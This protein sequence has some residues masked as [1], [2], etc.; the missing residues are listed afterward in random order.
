MLRRIKIVAGYDWTSRQANIDWARYSLVLDADDPEYI[1]MLTSGETHLTEADRLLPILGVV[2]EPLVADSWDDLC[3]AVF[4]H[5]VVSNNSILS[6]S[7]TWPW[8]PEA[9][10]SAHRPH[11][12]AYLTGGFRGR[13]NAPLRRRLRDALIASDVDCHLWGR[14][15]SG[16]KSHKVMGSYHRRD[17]SRI[18]TQYKYALAIE[19]QNIDN[20]ITEK[21]VNPINCGMQVICVGASNIRD[22]Y[23]SPIHLDTTR[24]IDHLKEL[25]SRPPDVEA[26]ARDREKFWDEYCFPARIGRYIASQSLTPH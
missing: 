19:N 22:Y 1:V 4:T 3:E 17:M 14:A 8:V 13:P 9:D 5:T 11:A 10:T 24:P 26:I 25:I 2:Q 21:V 12:L 20:Y 18:Y 23:D 6:H 15:L 16:L 7:C